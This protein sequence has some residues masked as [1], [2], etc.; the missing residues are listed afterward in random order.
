MTFC[1]FSTMKIFKE[2]LLKTAK[3]TMYK[4]KFNIREYT[5][6]NAY[7]YSCTCTNMY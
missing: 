2:N 1:E 5:S 4:L 3:E 6:E 7:W